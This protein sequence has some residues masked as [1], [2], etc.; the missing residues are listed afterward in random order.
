MIRSNDDANKQKSY[1]SALKMGAGAAGLG[2]GALAY[3]DGKKYVNQLR[4]MKNSPKEAKFVGALS[5]LANQEIA[6]EQSAKILDLQN[7]TFRGDVSPITRANKKLPSM[8]S[9]N[10]NKA[11]YVSDA[12]DNAQG[13]I[14][15][16]PNSKMA[17]A[18]SKATKLI[19][20]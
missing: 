16:A 8:K 11:Q 2:I 7:K 13:I 10:R 4:D 5:E 17:K 20:L 1:R 14:K 19:K 18:L 6:K 15:N 12:I 3:K 9:G